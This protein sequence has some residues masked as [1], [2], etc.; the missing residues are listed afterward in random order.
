MI[1]RSN[2]YNALME[3]L[4]AK[5][6]YCNSPIPILQLETHDKIC[7]RKPIICNYEGCGKVY[8]KGEMDDHLNICEFLRV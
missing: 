7:F 4:K 1:K 3:I 2:T 5:C 8:P 6:K